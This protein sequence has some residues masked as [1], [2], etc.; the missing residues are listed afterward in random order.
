MEAWEAA[1]DEYCGTVDG[2]DG[3][4]SKVA[5]DKEKKL[6]YAFSPIK[7]EVARPA[8]MGMPSKK[9]CERASKKDET[10]CAI[11]FPKPPPDLTLMSEEDIKKM[12]VRKLKDLLGEHGIGYKGLVEKDEF[13][14]LVMDAR[15]KAMA[16]KEAK[17]E[18]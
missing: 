15:A 13:V 5:D 14:K 8:A 12:R 4:K 10:I 1:I 6:C 16:K 2:W 3:Q 17:A 18:L 9:V 11:K 7:K